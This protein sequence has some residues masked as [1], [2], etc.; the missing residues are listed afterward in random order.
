MTLGPMY[1]TDTMIEDA[2]FIPCGPLREGE[3]IKARFEKTRQWWHELMGF[4]DAESPR[5]AAS[6][7]TLLAHIDGWADG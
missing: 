6:L 1:W 2:T 7:R 5:Y 3:D 4:L